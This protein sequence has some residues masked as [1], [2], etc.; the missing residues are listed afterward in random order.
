MP[1]RLKKWRGHVPSAPHQIAA[2]SMITQP[3]KAIVHLLRAG[4]S[5]CGAPFSGVCRNF[6]EGHQVIMVE[7]E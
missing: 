3:Q 1:R 4:L 7:I 5:K 2:M 6:E